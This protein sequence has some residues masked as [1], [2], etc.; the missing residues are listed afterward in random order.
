MG[1]LAEDLPPTPGTY[2]LHIRLHE[3]TQINV[4]RLGEVTLPAG[5][6]AYVGSALGPGG[7]RGR[8]GRHL[9]SDSV[10]RRHWHIDTL[11][12]AGDITEIWCVAGNDHL[13]CTWSAALE[14]IGRRPIQGFGASDCSCSS[15]LIY[16]E[17][18]AAVAQ[19]WK[20]LEGITRVKMKSLR[21]WDLSS[22]EIEDASGENI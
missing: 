11:A 8:I 14:G 12:A 9:R 10:K 21:L 19:A 3:K 5:S 18:N 15:H 2:L 22:S 20:V 4:G 16:L 1:K 6:F 13:E 17:N 7:L